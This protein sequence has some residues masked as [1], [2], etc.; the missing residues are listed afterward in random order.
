MLRSYEYHGYIIDV[1]AEPTFQPPKFG[2]RPM[3]V[4]YIALVVLKKN[5]RPV[6]TFSPLRLGDIAGR[7]F[8]SE[9]DAVMGGYGAA[10][11]IIDDL[12]SRDA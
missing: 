8:G 10:R 12:F 11:K 6:A 3:P 2:Q 4:G 5:G 7:A 9:V 1:E